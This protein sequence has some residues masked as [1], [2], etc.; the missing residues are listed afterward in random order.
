MTLAKKDFAHQLI[1][2]VK[3]LKSWVVT[4]ACCETVDAHAMEDKGQEI[5]D[6]NEGY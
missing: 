2:V 1:G 4:F 3:M 6:D 5:Q